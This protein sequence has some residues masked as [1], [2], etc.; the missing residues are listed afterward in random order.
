MPV[1]SG[2]RTPRTARTRSNGACARRGVLLLRARAEA[3]TRDAGRHSHLEE[4]EHD[5]HHLARSPLQAEEPPLLHARVHPVGRQRP[6]GPA[7]RHRW[8]RRAAALHELGRAARTRVAGHRQA[9]QRVGRLGDAK[10]DQAVQQVVAGERAEHG[11]AQESEDQHPSAITCETDACPCSQCTRSWE[12]TSG[13]AM[14]PK[15]S[16][17]TIL[18][19]GREL[20]HKLFRT[21]M[22][23]E[24]PL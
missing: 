11:D 1:V 17:T 8:P 21:Q 9:Q 6:R 7:A 3:R 2:E 19:R 14:R 15:H 20:G 16:L 12:P 5:V 10:L 24:R 23:A 18:S 4:G 22:A 13:L